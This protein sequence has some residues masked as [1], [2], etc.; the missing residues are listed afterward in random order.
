LRNYRL[1]AS[2]EDAEIL[3]PGE[4]NQCE[5]GEDQL[6]RDLEGVEHP[7]TDLAVE[8]GR[9]HPALGS[10]EHI[11]HFEPVWPPDGPRPAVWQQWLRF[12]PT[13]TFADPWVDAAR[14]LILVD[15][16]SWLS[17]HR[18]HVWR[19]PAFIAPTL[20][21]TVAFYQPASGD[22]WSLCDGSAPLST[23][24][25]IGWTARVWSTKAKLLASGGGQCLYRQLPAD[26]APG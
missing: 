11:R 25:L 7:R 26:T 1:G 24:G 3:T 10:G 6:R 8:C 19:R 4:L 14:P 12:S 18:A 23:R 9:C 13:A 20:D 5:G 16:P 17:A 2:I 15:P 21:L 22:E